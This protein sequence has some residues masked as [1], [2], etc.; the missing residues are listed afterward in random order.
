MAWKGDGSRGELTLTRR[1][2][3]SPPVQ[4]GATPLYIASEKGQL[5]VVKALI[6]RRADVEAKTHVRNAPLYNRSAHIRTRTRLTS[7]RR[8]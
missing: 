4:D 2:S 8:A 6:E 5:E 7:R 1:H 3:A